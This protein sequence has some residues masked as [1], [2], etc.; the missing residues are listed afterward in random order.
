MSNDFFRFPS[1]VASDRFSRRL[2]G[3]GVPSPS[4][5]ASWGNR[6]T[7]H[8][9]VVGLFHLR[10]QLCTETVLVYAQQ[11]TEM[12]KLNALGAPAVPPTQTTGCQVTSAALGQ[13][14][15]FF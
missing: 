6:W 13:V 12:E 3:R 15:I 14:G 7:P 1:A 2:E 4:A 8:A 5:G 9:S 11:K 10:L